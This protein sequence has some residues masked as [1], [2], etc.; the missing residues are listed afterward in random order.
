M[1]SKR[2][3]TTL[4][5]T[6]LATMLV[7]SL[8]LPAAGQTPAPAASPEPG[9]AASASVSGLNGPLI[10][11]VCLLSRDELIGKSKVG[12]AATARL[13]ALAAQAQ[14]SV[15][16]EKAR[17]EARGKALEA[18][19][20]TLTQEQF[21]AEAVAIQRRAQ[22]LQGDVAT[23]ER[24]I[25][26]TRNRAYSRVLAAAQPFVATSFADHKC[27]LLFAREAA[28]GGNYGNDLTSEVL[29]AFD[30]KGTPITVELEPAP[31]R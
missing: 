2:S 23:R 16:A 27:G 12:E 13:K 21:Q 8:A 10:P 20:A 6:I 31:T 29:T 30:A 19:R 4:R 18:K 28:L 17:L 11:G 24:Q 25:E 15:E 9:P 22:G 5:T 14:A 26:A 1:R 7:A 3:K